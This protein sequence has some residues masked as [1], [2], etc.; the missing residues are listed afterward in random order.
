[1]TIRA[2]VMALNAAIDSADQEGTDLRCCMDDIVYGQCYVQVFDTNECPST[3]TET[4]HNI[5][6]HR[7]GVI[8]NSFNVIVI[9]SA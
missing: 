9:L 3:S 5:S 6:I 2:A 8:P 1:M 7:H 4:S